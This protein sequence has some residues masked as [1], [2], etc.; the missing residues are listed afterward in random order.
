MIIGRQWISQPVSTLWKVL[1][2]CCWFKFP[3]L[4]PSCIPGSFLPFYQFWAKLGYLLLRAPSSGHP[5]IGPGLLELFINLFGRKDLDA[6]YLHHPEPLQHCQL[7]TSSTS[8]NQAANILSNQRVLTRYITTSQPFY[9]PLEWHETRNSLIFPAFVLDC[10][11]SPI[12][13]AQLQ[14]AFSTIRDTQL[15]LVVED[16]A[17]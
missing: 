3:T 7:S 2:G 5:S 8:C 1:G 4:I 17:S 16:A 9:N 15:H 13:E 6:Q 12:S 11:N 10:N 14:R